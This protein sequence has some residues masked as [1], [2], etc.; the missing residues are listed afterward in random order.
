MKTN[1]NFTIVY[2]IH[3]IIEIIRAKKR[4]LYE[5]FI[6]RN[7]KKNLSDLLNKI[8]SY[9]KII[10]CDKKQLNILAQTSDHQSIVAHTSIFPY[11]KSLLTNQEKNNIILVANRIQDTRNL[12]GLLRSAYCTNITQVIIE[13]KSGTEITGSVLKSAAGLAEHLHIYKT[14]NLESDLL[15]LKNKGFLILLAS[16]NGVDIDQIEI[17]S[18]LVLVIGNEHKGITKSLYTADTKIISLKQKEA[19]ISYNASVA[20][21]I[22]M[23]QLA[24]KLKIL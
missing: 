11:Q 8:P 19:N 4:K 16:A 7:I 6:D 18:S 23:Y 24:N 17:N 14:K 10:Y 9:T 20:G 13:E 15:T 2:G 3:P 21:G 5:V 12:G 1:D 22:L